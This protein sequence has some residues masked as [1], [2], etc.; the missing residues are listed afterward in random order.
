MQNEE[1]RLRGDTPERQDF[2][3]L[4]PDGMVD[5]ANVD[6]SGNRAAEYAAM[7]PVPGQPGIEAGRCSHAPCTCDEIRTERDGRGY[8]SDLCSDADVAAVSAVEYSLCPCMH[9][10]CEAGGDK[11]PADAPGAVTQSV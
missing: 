2:D 11:R 8:C 9:V 10:E 6:R 3:D 4:V 5:D 1:S 7:K